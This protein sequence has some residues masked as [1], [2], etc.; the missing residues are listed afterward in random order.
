M[1]FIKEIDLDVHGGLTY[2]NNYL[3]ISEN[4][5]VEGWI[6]IGWDYAHYG[7]YAG[8]EENDAKTI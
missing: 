4:K 1:I 5:K 7:D 2:S 6:F 3:C 8:Y